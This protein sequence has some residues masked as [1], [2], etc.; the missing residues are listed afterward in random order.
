[1]KEFSYTIKDKLGVHARPAGLLVKTAEK[2]ECEINI[3]HNEKLANAKKI[4]SVM[5]LG[6]H[7]GDKIKITASGTDESKAI[8]KIKKFFEENL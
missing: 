8:E 5:S 1:M 2:F 6:I 7:E 3:L 4:F